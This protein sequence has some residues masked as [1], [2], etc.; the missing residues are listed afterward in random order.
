MHDAET[1]AGGERGGPVDVP[2]ETPAP[3]SDG[4]PSAEPRAVDGG[5]PVA[6]GAAEPR[7]A[8]SRA[9]D[10]PPKRRTVNPFVELVLI[11]AA[12]FALWYVI[13]GWVVK[14]Y[15]IP[16]A[17]ME[18][19]LQEGDRV[20]VS[21]FTYRFHDPHRG[22]VI[23]FHPPGTGS[24]P[25]RGA[26]TEASV[27]FIK[28]VIG[29]PGET[30]QGIHGHV[31]VCTAPGRGCHVLNEPYVMQPGTTGD[32]GPVTVPAGNYFVMGDNRDD[33]DDSRDWG[34]VPRGYIIGEAF[35]IY[36]PLNRLSTL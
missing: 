26:T 8:S 14:P 21:R 28:R 17:S 34:T 12:A 6:G 29:L 27:N 16:S 4:A 22:D 23:V 7:G 25:Q 24:T 9:A 5:E 35:A 32:F 13:D 18:P 3:E 2:P 11:L 15:R 19:T 1:A 30:V 31:E 36:W 20:L 10:E 33:S